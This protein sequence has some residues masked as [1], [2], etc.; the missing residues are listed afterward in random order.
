MPTYDL[1]VEIYKPNLENLKKQA[2]QACLETQ[3][4]QERIRIGAAFGRVM[5]FT[6]VF[7]GRSCDG[8]DACS[9]GA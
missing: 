5:G 7:F 1:I 3:G 6:S 4:G 9:A 2:W 8:K